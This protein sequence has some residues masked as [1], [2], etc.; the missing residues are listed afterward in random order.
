MEGGELMFDAMTE[1]Q[2]QE[3]LILLAPFGTILLLLAV[4]SII[5][6]ER[7]GEN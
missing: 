1:T 4:T 6:A 3:W 7:K 5:Q 2:W